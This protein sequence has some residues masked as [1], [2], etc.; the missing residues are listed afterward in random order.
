MQKDSLSFLFCPKQDNC[1]NSIWGYCGEPMTVRGFT[2][3]GCCFSLSSLTVPDKC[4][5]SLYF[6]D[7]IRVSPIFKH[8][9]VWNPVLF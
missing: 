4:L 9:M 7:E 3:K 6:W 8:L 5:K 2:A 1:M